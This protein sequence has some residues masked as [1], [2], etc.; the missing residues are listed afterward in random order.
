MGGIWST[1][2]EPART[3][4]RVFKLHIERSR[5]GLKLTTFVPSN[6]CYTF[7][8]FWCMNIM[9]VVSLSSKKLTFVLFILCCGLWRLDSSAQVPE[10]LFLQMIPWCFHP[11]LG[12]V[13]CSKLSQGRGKNARRSPFKSTIEANNHHMLFWSARPGKSR[14]RW[15]GKKEKTIYPNFQQVASRDVPDI[16]NRPNATV[17]RHL[18]MYFIH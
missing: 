4:G 12:R 15:K 13:K 18:W 10:G 1:W 16:T 5:A 7:Y 9:A 8:F 6:N 11:G 3:P 14:K 17:F 2:R